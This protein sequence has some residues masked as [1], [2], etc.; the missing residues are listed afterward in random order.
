[1]NFLKRFPWWFWIVVILAILFAWQF[2]S[3]WSESRKLYNMM[4]DQLREDQ[5]QVIQ[6]KEAWI[7]DCEK[8]IS[9]LYL[10][11][12]QVKK[13]RNIQQAEN[14]RLMEVIRG[15]QARREDIVVPDDPDRIVDQFH[16]LGFRSIHRRKR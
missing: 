14:G 9:E 6:D 15:L 12:D 8:E 2:V 7:A 1:M 4:I 11:L 10:E 16:S 13:L 5:N 3:G